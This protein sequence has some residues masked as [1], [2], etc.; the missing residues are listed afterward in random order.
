MWTTDDALSTDSSQCATK[1]VVPIYITLVFGGLFGVTLLGIFIKCYLELR[2]KEM[3][4]EEAAKKRETKSPTSAQSEPEPP[5]YASVEAGTE[6]TIVVTTGSQMEDEKE[7]TKEDKAHIALP[8][9]S[10]MKDEREERK[11]LA[12]FFD[13]LR[14][15]SK[16][17]MLED[18]DKSFS[19]ALLGALMS[20]KDIYGAPILHL[21]DVVSDYGSVSEFA[22]LALSATKSDCNDLDPVKVFLTSASTM[23]LY[24]VVSAYKM[25][26]ITRRGDDG[27]VDA[28]GNVRK[29]KG[30]CL[31]KE[32]YPGAG[33]RVAGQLVDVELFHI[34][35]LSHK[36]G[37]K[38]NSAPQRMLSA[39]E[40]TLEGSPQA[41]IQ[42][43]FL[44]YT[45]S[46]SP[47]I[48]ASTAFSFIML[49]L[50]VV[51]DDA[52]FMEWKPWPLNR[53]SALPYFLLFAFRVCDVPGRLCMYSLL[54]YSD[55][56]WVSGTLVALSF[57]IG[58]AIYQFLDTDSKAKGPT[59]AL[60]ML[61]ATPLSFAHKDRKGLLY[62][63]WFYLFVEGMMA[64]WLLWSVG[65]KLENAELWKVN[66][67]YFATVASA[68]K[69]LY[70]VHGVFNG[71]F[72]SKNNDL[73]TVCKERADLPALLQNQEFNEV[74]ELVAFKR[75]GMKGAGA[76]KYKVE[77]DAE[78]S[79]VPASV[80]CI[81]L[82][83]GNEKLYE[84]LWNELSADARRQCIIDHGKLFDGADDK[85]K[86]LYF[87]YLLKCW[88]YDVGHCRDPDFCA[89]YP[90]DDMVEFAVSDTV[91]QLIRDQKWTET[92]HR[93]FSDFLSHMARLAKDHPNDWRTTVV[94]SA[95][96]MWEALK[97]DERRQCII[98]Y[99]KLMDVADDELRGL[100]SVYLLKYWQ[101]ARTEYPDF[102]DF[103]IPE[104]LKNQRLDHM[105][106]SAEANWQSVAVLVNHGMA[107]NKKYTDAE[108]KRW[109]QQMIYEGLDILNKPLWADWDW[110]LVQSP[111]KLVPGGIHQSGTQM[112][113]GRKK[114]GNELIVGKVNI[115][116]AIWIPCNGMEITSRG[117][118]SLLVSSNPKLFEWVDCDR[119]VPE[120]AVPGGRFEDGT[121][122]YIGRFTVERQEAV[123]KVR[124]GEGCWVPYGG[125]AHFTEKFKCLVQIKK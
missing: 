121:P 91:I 35:H 110:D 11:E 69:W 25:W 94:L 74:A 82:G 8:T 118:Y 93:H 70:F 22:I 119:S 106:R 99:G 14:V 71:G 116:D 120:G 31:C 79:I 103:I 9:G 4:K 124:D 29:A 90:F 98:D 39:L 40:A 52:H 77:E 19:G 108:G 80:F 53:E 34:T 5:S 1:S 27:E 75:G 107:G 115:N 36:I 62:C 26:Q 89:K 72:R 63:V 105:K 125:R 50:N 114:R 64:R 2:A 41:T 37:L 58:S 44:L 12:E 111:M 20:K 54:W 32:G 6:T 117:D 21:I 84:T 10:Q 92:K 68:I 28:N 61:V 73:T 86:G 102:A 67:A 33:W 45:D 100:Y 42:M 65:S 13:A 3:K 49:T 24:R 38:G 7:E 95:D 15:A 60:L 88:E 83:T 113:I 66:L 23:V 16:G 18:E 123:G 104:M 48:L 96:T 46:S 51:N 101:W 87:E 30:R 78:G 59:D 76:A 109:N 85:R 56:G 47:V 17:A 122:M 81:A 57:A 112:Y 97:P 55:L 43:T